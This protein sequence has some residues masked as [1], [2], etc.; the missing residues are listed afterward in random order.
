MKYVQVVKGRGHLDSCLVPELIQIQPNPN[1]VKPVLRAHPFC[2]QQVVLKD[3]WSLKTVYYM[4]YIEKVQNKLAS[5][6][7][8]MFHKE[9]SLKTGSTVISDKINCLVWLIASE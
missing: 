3:R 5:Q 6:K 4:D 1:T 7:R 8:V 9:R 2:H